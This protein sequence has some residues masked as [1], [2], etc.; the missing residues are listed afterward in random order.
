MSAS[1]RVTLPCNQVEAEALAG[2]EDLWGDV[3][4][5]PALSGNPSIVA[6]EADYRIDPRRS[7]SWVI[8]AYYTAK[9]KPRWIA[10]LVAA[11]P[12]AKGIDPVIE[13]VPDQDWLVVSQAGLEPIR[14]GRFHVHTPDMPPGAEPGT[15]NLMI[16]A[17]LA[18]GTGHHETTRGCLTMLDRLRRSGVLVRS[19]IDIGTGTGLL[20]FA[21]LRLWPQ[22]HATASD[23]DPV[24]AQ[25]V[26]ENAIANGIMPG[27]GRGQLALRIADGLA[28]PDL[29]GRA[30]YDLII[31]NILAAPLIAMAGDI[32][33]V[34][35]PGTHLI[36]AGLLNAQA[37]S[38]A[39]AYRREGFRL[40]SRLVDG[41]WTILH[42]RRRRPWR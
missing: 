13:R 23:I 36:L 41:D 6:S 19:L 18:F 9:P 40:A 39:A 10:R 3:E 42:L 20:G 25:V 7:G 31:A 28:D 8:Q 2:R 29:Q 14:A 11:A 5:A 26:T 27:H 32:A 1:W 30:P 15:Q 24:C 37:E 33:A 38:V 4:T 17:G 16:P 21:A 12:S 35:Q 34:A 22:A